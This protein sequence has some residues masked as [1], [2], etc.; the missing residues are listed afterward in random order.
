M[1]FGSKKNKTTPEK[2][3]SDKQ[4]DSLPSL[5]PEINPIFLRSTLSLSSQDQ[6]TTVTSKDSDPN[7]SMWANTSWEIHYVNVPPLPPPRLPA[8]EPIVPALPPRE[9]IVP[10][11][12]RNED[13]ITMPPPNVAPEGPL[14]RGKKGIVQS[15]EALRSACNGNPEPEDFARKDSYYSSHSS[16]ES[17]V[18][19][20]SESGSNASELTGSGSYAESANV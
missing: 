17:E 14:T 7:S 11:A 5:D 20:L 8:R 1:C 6:H 16:L 10:E 9:P 15:K 3:T 2:T 13:K 12:S 19:D 4:A 18:L